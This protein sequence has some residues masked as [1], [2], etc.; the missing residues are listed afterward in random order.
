LTQGEGAVIDSLLTQIADAPNLAPAQ[1]NPALDA[2]AVK[3]SLVRRWL[4][5]NHLSQTLANDEVTKNLTAVTDFL[6]GES[7]SNA[8]DAQA[9]LQ[10]AESALQDLAKLSG[11]VDQLE[12][13]LA[14]WRA[15]HPSSAP[16]MAATAEIQAKIEEARRRL[17]A[18]ESDA[19]A[20]LTAAR[21]QW[22]KQL[23]AE[24]R[25][26]FAEPAPFNMDTGQ[27]AILKQ[28]A[29]ESA[30]ALEAA[31]TTAQAVAAYRGA[32]N[33]T[34]AGLA[35]GLSD[36]ATQAASAGGPQAA[37]LQRVRTRAAEAA[38]AAAEGRLDQAQRGYE[39]A[40]ILFTQLGAAGT[41]QPAAGGDGFESFAVDSGSPP[42]A[43]QVGPVLSKVPTLVA[44]LPPPRP[45]LLNSA[46]VRRQ[47]YTTE[48]VAQGILLIIAVLVGLQALWVS[49]ATWGSPNDY[50]LAIGWGLGLQLVGGPAAF[51]GIDSLRSRFGGGSA[52]PEAGQQ[53]GGP[54]AG[55]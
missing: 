10:K 43:P 23:A 40:S 51:Q 47:I 49:N 52:A 26:P 44:P 48:A 11:E 16:S 15:S 7:A 39:A 31:T 27:W 50:L 46:D 3:V 19:E 20:S 14:E 54:G 1:A 35:Q 30:T 38:T 29:E 6:T 41:G 18:R 24:V 42:S 2:L 28:Q 12:H 4:N 32:V 55:Q 13:A 17:A 36:A 21:Q 34:I 9:A 37:D 8:A 53:G 5:A 33:A 22:I 25:A 45:P